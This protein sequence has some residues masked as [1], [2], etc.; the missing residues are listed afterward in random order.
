M[1]CSNC[2]KEYK[3]K[4]FSCPYCGAINKKIYKDT[5]KKSKNN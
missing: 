1:R 4:L 5:V 2:K 3:D